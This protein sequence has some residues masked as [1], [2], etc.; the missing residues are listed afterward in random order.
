[1]NK[2]FLTL[3]K[4]LA[5]LKRFRDRSRNLSSR[6][7]NIFTNHKLHLISYGDKKYRK[8]K[9]R[10]FNEA[11]RSNWFYSI[12]I[13][14]EKDLS[15]A[16]RNEFQDLLNL[17]KGG[18]CY[19]W[20][21][22]IILRK[23]A[24]INSGDFLIYLD[25]G[26]SI[27]EAGSKR[28]EEYIQIIKNDEYKIISFQMNFLDQAFTT[29]QIFNA[30]GIPINDEVERTGQFVGGILIMQKCNDVIKIFE[31]C[32]DKIRKDHLLITDHYNTDQ[33][34]IFRENR[35]DQSILSVARKK[36]GSIVIPDETYF[37]DFNSESALKTPFLATRKRRG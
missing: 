3:R 34:D 1:M 23:L 22:Y 28:L 9:E 30:F 14:G 10:L 13:F 16:F 35:H 20:K 21:F 4:I 37:L 31:D 25:S 33:F 26:C 5:I 24:E 27:N 12:N 18:G 15:A 8:T 7:R 36:H 6:P 19:V 11:I 32:L 2:V 29:R 17:E